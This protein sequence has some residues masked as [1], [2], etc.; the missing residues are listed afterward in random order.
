MK[1]C[2]NNLGIHQQ[3]YILYQNKIIC[4]KA[5]SSGTL[6]KPLRTSIRNKVKKIK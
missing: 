6:D 4:D 2:Y 1:C 5:F 3:Y